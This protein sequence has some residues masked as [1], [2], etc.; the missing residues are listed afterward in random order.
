MDRVYFNC[1]CAPDGND[2]LHCEVQ[3]KRDGML[4]VVVSSGYSQ[5]VLEFP[6]TNV[7][8][9]EYGNNCR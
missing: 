1:K 5:T 7:Q 2:W 3:A 8:R 4:K 6:L 9:I